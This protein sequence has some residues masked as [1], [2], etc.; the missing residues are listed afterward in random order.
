M[1][2]ITPKSPMIRLNSN[3]QQRKPPTPNYVKKSQE[4]VKAVK[5]PSIRSPTNS[6]NKN[7]FQIA[8]EIKK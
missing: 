3:S 6:L 1:S 2:P 8:S 4:I 5:S 7:T